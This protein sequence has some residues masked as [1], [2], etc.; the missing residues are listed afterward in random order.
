MCAPHNQSCG[1][2]YGTET[3]GFIHA[4]GRLSP[5]VSPDYVTT[6]S[7]I[8]MYPQPMPIPQAAMRRGDF[9]AHPY[10]HGNAVNLAAHDV[11][12]GELP[13]GEFP[14]LI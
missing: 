8:D 13:Y 14:S 1:C 2:E 5:V 10:G 7:E 12:V 4:A 6:D 9:L 11:G 3:R